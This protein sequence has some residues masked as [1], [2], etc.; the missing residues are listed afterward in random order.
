MT[1]NQTDRLTNGLSAVANRLSSLTH[2]IR[3]LRGLCLG[4]ET[5]TEECLGRSH[6]SRLATKADLLK[7]EER[8]KDMEK[9][10]DD[11]VEEVRQANTVANGLIVLTGEIKS[12]LD[13][14]LAGALSPA[15]QAKV[16]QVWADVNAEK[17][18]LA[19]ALVANTPTSELR[20]GTATTAKR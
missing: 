13:L 17:E 15:N 12:K 11:V 6:C 7:L 10:L 8:L 9:T 18:A 2:A 14:A 19:A 16:D 20:G 1:D 4:E 3:G 5:E